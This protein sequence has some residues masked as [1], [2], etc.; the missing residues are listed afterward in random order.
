MRSAAWKWGIGA[1]ILATVGIATML[2]GASLAALLLPLCTDGQPAGSI[3]RCL[4]PQYY[5][6]AGY[7]FLAAALAAFMKCIAILMKR[8][9]V[10]KPPS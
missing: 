9:T 4:G 7:A 8:G 5:T 3:S 10:S 6:I 1:L 2:L